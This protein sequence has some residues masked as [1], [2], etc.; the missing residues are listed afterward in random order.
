MKYGNLGLSN[1]PFFVLALAIGMITVSCSKNV[2]TPPD[3]HQV[4]QKES[5]RQRLVLT[6]THNEDILLLPYED[7]ME[8]VSLAPGQRIQFIFHVLVLEDI[9]LS[10]KYPWYER[11]GTFTC[12]IEETSNP[13]FLKAT[14]PD[15]VKLQMKSASGEDQSVRLL[16]GQFDCPGGSWHQEGVEAAFYKVNS[17][18]QSFRLCPRR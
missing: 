13:K 17:G 4:Q 5:P 14:G 8:P 15:E 11:S 16:F 7:G 2:V 1:R 12:Y 9:T 3:I 6:N 18:D 10:T